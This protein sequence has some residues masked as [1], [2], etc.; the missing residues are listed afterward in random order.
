[1]S[2]KFGVRIIYK[3]NTV[4]DFSWMF[5]QSGL[6]SIKPVLEIG[7][8]QYVF[9]AD[10]SFMRMN[11]LEHDADHLLHVSSYLNISGKCNCSDSS[12]VMYLSVYD[13]EI[14]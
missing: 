13:T 12:F 14:V 11:W 3:K 10:G 9:S 5:K 8:E 4:I 6:S 2:K 1:M 7:K